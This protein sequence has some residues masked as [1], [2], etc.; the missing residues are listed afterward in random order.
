M[1]ATEKLIM[2]FTDRQR[3]YSLSC[4]QGVLVTDIRIPMQQ[5]LTTQFASII[6]LM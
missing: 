5:G 1:M 6:K 2:L 4:V 3:I